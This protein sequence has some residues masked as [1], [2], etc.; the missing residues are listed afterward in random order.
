MNKG[1]FNYKALF[2]TVSAILICCMIAAGIIV[3]KVINA[4]QQESR[5]AKI[6]GLFTGQATIIDRE[7]PDIAVYTLETVGTDGAT[8]EVAVADF[9]SVQSIISQK[10]IKP[11][12]TTATV[13]TTPTE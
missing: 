8:Y 2:I 10:V 7:T 5:D 12:T 3:P 6:K 11:A 9:G 4:S 13:T 1:K